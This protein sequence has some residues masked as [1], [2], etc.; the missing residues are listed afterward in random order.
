MSNIDDDEECP[1]LIPA[2]SPQLP[3][4]KRAQDAPRVA[5][6]AMAAATA[7]TDA[8]IPVTIISGFLGE[9]ARSS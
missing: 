7:E 4:G 8:K 3:L 2:D 1:A 9:A 6:T 5:A